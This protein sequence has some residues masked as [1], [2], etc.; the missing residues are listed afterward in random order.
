MIVT[1]LHLK[2]SSSTGQPPLVVTNLGA[3]T[4]FVG[5]N[6]SG[7]SQALR[8][9]F[10]LCVYEPIGTPLQIMDKLKFRGFSKDT[11]REKIEKIYSHYVENK[12]LPPKHPRRVGK[13]GMPVTEERILFVMENPN[14]NPFDF[15]NLYL[16]NLVINLDGAGRINLANNQQRHDLKNPQTPFA[17][18]LTNDLKRAQ[19]RKVIFDGIGLY[20]A[21][22][23]SDGNT[24]HLRFGTKP[25]PAERNVEDQTL[26]YMRNARGIEAVSDGVKAFTGILLQ[27]YAGDPE[28]TVIDEPEAFLHPSLASRLGKEIARIAASEDKQVFAATHSPQFLM[29]AIQSGAKVNIIRLTYD[30][31]IGTA[32]LLPAADLT[33]LMQD[34]LLRSV[35]VIEGLF[36]NSVIVCEGDS[37]RAFYQEIN[38]RLLAA[39]D[40]RGIPHALVLNADNKQT[41]SRIA[42][43]LRK[44]GI[45]CAEVVD[46]D[47]LKDGGDEW[48]RH[49]RACGI[50]PIEHPSYGDRR[51]AVLKL[52]NNRNPDFK[53]CGGVNLLAGSEREAADNLLRNLSEYG[54]FIVP[55]GEIE[56]WL[57]E[58]G[59]PRSK[60]GWRSAIFGKMGSDP[61]SPDYVK[62]SDGDAWDFIG[63]LCRWLRDPQRKGIPA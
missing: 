28:I 10:H 49:L 8:E 62:A 38:E 58:L 63:G 57:P 26:E 42:D 2:A 43:L 22:D 24:L 46:I 61:Q 16:W 39:N 33:R 9:I 27:L 5:P 11:A 51:S 35:G 23:M 13:S 45:P 56:A 6:N 60:H 15:S 19:W 7:K 47:V 40:S 29:G 50:P 30:G 25:P 53:R 18:L 36:Y 55:R 31:Q 37:D 59:V 34:P 20:P 3:V 48:T 14:Q 44:L 12:S 41:V 52:L 17:R 32:R 1:E 21:I 54:F 4:I